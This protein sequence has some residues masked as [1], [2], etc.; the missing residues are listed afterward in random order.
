MGGLLERVRLFNDGERETLI[1]FL[2]KN[3]TVKESCNHLINMT[4]NKPRLSVNHV[5]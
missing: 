5:E 2:E 3:L 4:V 1:L